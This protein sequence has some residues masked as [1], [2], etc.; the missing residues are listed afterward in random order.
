MRR[1]NPQR[2]EIGGYQGG[3]LTEIAAHKRSYAVGFFGQ[4]KKRQ[5]FCRPWWQ[6]APGQ[7]NE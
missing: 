3:D 7:S 6:T 4:A 2:T 1:K 5:S